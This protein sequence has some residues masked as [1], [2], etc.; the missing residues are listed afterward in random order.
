MISHN[1]LFSFFYN[2]TANVLSRAYHPLYRTY[3]PVWRRGEGGACYTVTIRKKNKYYCT[4]VDC[5]CNRYTINT[6]STVSIVY[7]L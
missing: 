1:T 2:E 5:I 4:I 3:I 7:C 6:I